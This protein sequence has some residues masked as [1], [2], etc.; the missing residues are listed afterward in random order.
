MGQHGLWESRGRTK[1]RL[2]AKYLAAAAALLA[3]AL[4]GGCSSQAEH[5]QVE[6]QQT[7]EAGSSVS[8]T[9]NGNGNDPAEAGGSADTYGEVVLDRNGVNTI[10]LRLG[11]ERLVQLCMAE[12]GFEYIGLS[13]EQLLSGER[14]RLLE[15]RDD[16]WTQLGFAPGETPSAGY[17]MLERW[18]RIEETDA[19]VRSQQDRTLAKDADARE[20]FSVALGGGGDDTIMVTA[21]NGAE[22]GMDRGGCRAQS[23]ELIYGSLEDYIRGSFTEGNLQIHVMGLVNGDLDVIARGTDW[24]RCLVGLGFNDSSRGELVVHVDQL[25][26]EMD[27]FALSEPL[28]EEIALA[29]ADVE[30][31]SEVGFGQAAYAMY[32][33]AAA[34]VLGENE[35]VLL[36]LREMRLAALERLQE[37]LS[38]A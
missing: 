20:A 7:S 16:M 12:R 17:G 34:Q 24:Q 27:V 35:G 4:L 33:Q 37:L 26:S 2:F 1:L 10:E 11:E 29:K 3:I 32:D 30:C 21:L 28:A 6:E 14:D 19:I 5:T 9:G 25:Y 15:H 38:D 18:R 22:V 8:D 31:S 36:G 23:L 13:R